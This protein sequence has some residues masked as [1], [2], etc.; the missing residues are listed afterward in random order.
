MVMGLSP[1]NDKI[2]CQLC[3]LTFMLTIK[4]MICGISDN[5]NAGRP[6]ILHFFF[7]KLDRSSGFHIND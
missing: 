1:P 3:P 5:P 7:F 4:I 2:L 6:K